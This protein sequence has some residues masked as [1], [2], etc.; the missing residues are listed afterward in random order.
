MKDDTLISKLSY[1]SDSIWS[2][3]MR[4][5]FRSLFGGISWPQ[6]IS[7]IFVCFFSDDVTLRDDG[8]KWAYNSVYIYIYIIFSSLFRWPQFFLPLVHIEPHEIAKRGSF[9]NLEMLT[10]IRDI[11]KA[12]GTPKIEYIFRLRLGG[13][14]IT[15]L[16]A[17]FRRIPEDPLPVANIVVGGADFWTS[18]NWDTERKP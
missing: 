6:S 12:A 8:W 5:R 4:L 2:I 18:T 3:F 11:F 7:A 13:F 10:T 15:P 16:W 9:R 14:N 17:Y 1:H